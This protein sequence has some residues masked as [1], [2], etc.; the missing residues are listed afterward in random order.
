MIQGSSIGD[1]AY[2][3]CNIAAWQSRSVR[4]WPSSRGG[5]GFVGAGRDRR[6]RWRP[7]T[8]TSMS[9]GPRND[10][11]SPVFSGDSVLMAAACDRGESRRRGRARRSFGTLDAPKTLFS[12]EP[13][14]TAG[15]IRHER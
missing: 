12:D 8:R 4:A 1:L 15:A 6:V 13:D 7:Q 11:A 2:M 14:L 9:Q 10:V 3:A 5:G